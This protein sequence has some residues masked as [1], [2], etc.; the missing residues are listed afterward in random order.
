MVSAQSED[1]YFVFSVVNDSAR[2][3]VPDQDQWVMGYTIITEWEELVYDVNR[4]ASTP[5]LYVRVPADYLGSPV[6]I[7][8]RKDIGNYVYRMEL[9]LLTAADTE[10]KGCYR[11]MTETLRFTE[12]SYQ[13]DVPVLPASW[14]LL[15]EREMLA[16]GERILCKDISMLQA[17]LLFSTY[18]R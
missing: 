5:L 10:Q 12:G 7:E 6:K 16:G 15:P 13:L 17:I 3:L 11:C 9:V 1:G 18:T 4:V 14:E 2:F 8:L